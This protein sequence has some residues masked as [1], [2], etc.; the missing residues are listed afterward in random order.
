VK[1]LVLIAGV[2]LLALHVIKNKTGTAY[3]TDGVDGS[4]GTTAVST[5]GIGVALPMPG[6]STSAGHTPAAATTGSQS[7]ANPISIGSDNPITNVPQIPSPSPVMSG[8]FERMDY[9]H[10]GTAFRSRDL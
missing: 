10:G 8:A 7:K 4:N 6:T 3:S 5:H 2:A 1:N 9:L